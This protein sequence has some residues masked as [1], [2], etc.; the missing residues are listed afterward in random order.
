MANLFT[1]N[2]FAHGTL[3]DI[4]GNAFALLAHFSRC[5][6]RSGWTQADIDTVLNKARESDYDSLVGCLSAHLSLEG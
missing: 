1:P 4:D 5:A 6:R 2:K 3:A